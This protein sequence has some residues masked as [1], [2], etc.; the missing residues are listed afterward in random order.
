MTSFMNPAYRFYSVL[1]HRWQSEDGAFACTISDNSIT[2]ET[3]CGSFSDHYSP[4]DS[5]M[6]DS[7]NGFGMMGV[8]E[9]FYPGEEISLHLHYKM[10]PLRQSEAPLPIQKL[11][12]GNRALHLVYLLPTGEETEAV[13][14]VCLVPATNE[15]WECACGYTGKKG[16]FCPNC[17]AA[18]P[19]D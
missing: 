6:P 10:N 8:A 3:P 2:L 7:S 14:Q 18:R 17:G 15:D 16:N 9:R 19:K 5:V 13:M 12:Y 1:N 11:W 4:S